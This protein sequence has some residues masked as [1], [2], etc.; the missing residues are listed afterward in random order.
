MAYTITLGIQK[1]GSSKTTTAGILAYCLSLLEYRV[2]AVDMDSQANLS[3][4]LLHAEIEELLEQEKIPGT[5]MDAF[6]EMNPK[7][8]I[9]RAAENLDVLPSEDYLATFSRWLYR[10]Y[11][12]E[13]SGKDHNYALK[14]LL[15]PV[16]DVYDYI[17][18]D[19]PPA[20]SDQTLNALSASD[21]VIILFEPSLFSYRAIGRFMETIEAAQKKTNP[22]LRVL[23]I[24]ACLLDMRRKDNVAMIRAV[25]E[26]FP[27]LLFKTQIRRKAEIGR[28]PIE[29]FLNN[30]EV[31]EA[32]KQY[33]HFLEKELLPRVNR[34]KKIG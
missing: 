12:P 6:E 24:L 19:T 11:A 31:L 8:Y 33:A 27:G 15:K 30:P 14:N 5:I 21:G 9:V 2:L 25:E 32:V 4:M 34:E 7:P 16:Q 10:E 13:G 28:L 29:G 26:E 22:N 18:I 1:G 23:G 20:L 17:I 3:E